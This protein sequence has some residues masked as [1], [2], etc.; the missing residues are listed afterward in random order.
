MCA[1]SACEAPLNL[2]GVARQMANP[3]HR[4]D[5][6]Q[7]AESIDDVTVVVGAYG[8]VLISKDHGKSWRRN[9]LAGKPP[10][11]DIAKC[12]NNSLVALDYKGRV[13]LSRDRGE[14]WRAR[15]IDSSEVPQALACDPRGTIWVVGSYSTIMSSS[16]GGQDWRETSLDE[17]LIL[18]SIQFINHQ[19]AVITGE[20]GAFIT[21]ADAGQSW[22]REGPMPN[23]F[24]P[25]ASFFES[26]DA[27]WVV[28]LNGRIYHTRD[29]GKTW[30]Q[31]LAATDS[32]L[33]GITRLNNT[34]VSV[35]ER[36]TVLFRHQAGQWKRLQSS[37]AM[38]NFLRVVL[39]VKQPDGLLVAGSGGALRLINL[40]DAEENCCV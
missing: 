4:F 18:T 13:W 23:E 12:P 37:D 8:V 17:D 16:N 36:G 2:Q 21:S 26:L 1:V 15:K 5:Q 31:E 14:H 28:G 22:R 38:Q 3:V 20:F 24:Y 35:G 19:Q 7:A 32:P 25:Q 11:I 34:L 33:Y 9:Q 40:F 29:R 30:Q 6:F 10:L 39:P 27:G